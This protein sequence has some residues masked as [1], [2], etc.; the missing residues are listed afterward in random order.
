MP[1]MRGY[2]VLSATHATVIHL[3]GMWPVEGRSSC[4]SAYCG[5]AE[6]RASTNHLAARGH[7]SMTVRTTTPCDACY[8]LC[9][10]TIL[11]GWV[12]L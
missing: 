4:L 10:A 8:G 11:P 1:P 7:K 2:R 5:M 6:H 3:E 9:G 12:R